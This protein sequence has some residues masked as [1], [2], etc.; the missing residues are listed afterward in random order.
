MW[1]SGRGG[2]KV[3]SNPNQEKSAGWAESGAQLCIPHK[4]TRVEMN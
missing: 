2:R 4:Q 3:G 1:N